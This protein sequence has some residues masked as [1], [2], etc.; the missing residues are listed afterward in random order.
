MA[1]I[2]A[3]SDDWCRF[4]TLVPCTQFPC[5]VS[6]ANAVPTLLHHGIRARKIQALVRK[7]LSRATDGTWTLAHLAEG[8]LGKHQYLLFMKHFKGSTWTW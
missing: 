2:S 6:N 1:Q 7:E 4:L 8:P 5:T 3:R